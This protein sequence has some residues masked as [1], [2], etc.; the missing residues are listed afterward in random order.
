MH[1]MSA[2]LVEHSQEHMGSLHVCF[3]SVCLAATPAT[4]PASD[5][6]LDLSGEVI[7]TSMAAGLSPVYINDNNFKKILFYFFNILCY[8]FFFS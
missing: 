6:I 5:K 3:L 7:E 2:T 4:T 1:L 8:K